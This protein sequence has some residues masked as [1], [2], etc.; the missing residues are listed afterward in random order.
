MKRIFTIAI[1]LLLA[2]CF[3][4]TPA[5]A[6]G[7]LSIA[8]ETDN[9][10]S[11]DVNGDGVSDNR[12]AATVLKYD[13]GLI[14]EDDLA[15]SEGDIN[16]DGITN[17][18]DASHILKY[19]A[20]LVSEYKYCIP[21]M[22]NLSFTINST[23]TAYTVGCSG[24][25]YDVI[26]LVVFPSTYNGLPVTRVGG[27]AR[28]VKEIYIPEGVLVINDDAFRESDTLEKI[29]IPSSVLYIGSR[30]LYNVPKL[31]TLDFRASNLL[32]CKAD[33]S[34]LPSAVRSTYNGVDYLGNANNKYLYAAY[35]C[36]IKEAVLHPNTKVIGYQAFSFSWLTLE[37]VKFNKGLRAICSHA[38]QGCGLIKDINLPEGLV[39]VMGGA[40][41]HAEEA[42]VSLPSSVMYLGVDPFSST[43]YTRYNGFDYLGNEKNPYHALMRFNIL[44]ATDDSK[45]HKDTKIIAELACSATSGPVNLPEGLLVIGGGAFSSYTVTSGS[46]AIPSTVIYIGGSAFNGCNSREDVV[47]PKGLKHLGANAFNGSTITG[48]DIRSNIKYI[49]KD[50]FA[51]TTALKRITLPKGLRSIGDGAFKIDYSDGYLAKQITIPE[52]VE[53]IGKEAFGRRF[54]E[55]G[56]AD[57][58]LVIPDSVKEMGIGAFNLM[59]YY[60][61]DQ[62]NKEIKLSASCKV[63]PLNAFE[64]HSITSLTVPEGVISIEQGA[65]EDNIYLEKIYVG[66]SLKKLGCVAFARCKELKDIYYSGTKADWNAI[67]KFD[68]G[69]TGSE[70]NAYCSEIT[71][72]CADGNLIVPAWQQ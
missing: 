58:P 53:Y 10:A 67:E 18:I 2:A 44:D 12:D 55:K 47:L 15:L 3:T 14:N 52:G 40:F 70:W 56:A 61:T 8:E 22:D 39:S 20:G 68:Q 57:T 6:E 19:D 23:H 46:I 9:T 49:S 13:A 42:T 34:M 31:K 38:F 63:I 5:F 60:G 72:H 54:Y 30:V 69:N 16:A 48:I 17:N 4:L 41:S 26:P 29:N 51:N 45:L 11:G 35:A 50:A 59:A 24:G 65:F 43:C 71:V 62:G 64:G 66:K 37:T 25:L 28:N 1:S 33:F 21:T 36:D 27:V 7:A 32:E